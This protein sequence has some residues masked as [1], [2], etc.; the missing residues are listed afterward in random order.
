MC[1]ST[2]M[3]VHIM[4]KVCMHGILS[5]VGGDCMHVMVCMYSCGMYMCMCMHI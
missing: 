2:C 3:A 4:H 5:M 1:A